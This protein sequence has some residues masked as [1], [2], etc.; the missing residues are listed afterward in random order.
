MLIHQ[1]LHELIFT[2]V[3]LPYYDRELA[4]MS[5][6]LSAFDLYQF[7]GHTAG[8]IRKQHSL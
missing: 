3:L 5:I 8:Y 7:K 6:M 4:H 1:N 2:S